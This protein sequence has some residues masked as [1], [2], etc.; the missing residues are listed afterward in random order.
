MFT[1]LYTTL[2]SSELPL[3]MDRAAYIIIKN[4][5]PFVISAEKRRKQ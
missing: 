4:Q 3:Q 2:P 1:K 5:R